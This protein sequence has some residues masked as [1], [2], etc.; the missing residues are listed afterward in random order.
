MI[1]QG[2]VYDYISNG[3]AMTTVSLFFRCLVPLGL[4][5]GIRIRRINLYLNG[6][7]VP[8]SGKVM[9]PARQ[10]KSPLLLLIGVFNS[11]FCQER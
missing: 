2:E 3:A 6:F 1:S 11:T 4:V 9:N 7:D 10:T 5:C 8:V